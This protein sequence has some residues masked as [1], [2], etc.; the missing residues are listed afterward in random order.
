MKLST[1]RILT[2]HTGSLPRP[3]ELVRLTY[4]QEDGKPV[5]HDVMAAAQARAVEQVVR[6]QAEAGIDVISDGE[7]AKPGFINYLTSRLTGYEGRAG[8]WV[9]DDLK[10]FP[11]L[12]MEQYGGEAGA[13][14][15]MRTCT[16]DIRYVGQD[17]VAADIAM[18]SNTIADAGVVEG[19]LPAASPGSFAMAAPNQHY[20]S[21]E[22][23]LFA[24]ARA[25]REEYRAVVGSGLLLQLDCPDLPM[26]M[27]TTGWDDTAKRIGY[28]KYLELHVAAL[29]EAVADLP[30]DR[31]RMHICWGNYEGPHHLDVPLTE[32]LPAVFEARPAAIS[33]EAANPRHEHEWED[34]A[35]LK[36]PDDKIL[37]PG[38]IDVKTNVLEHPRLVAQRVVRFADI[39][40]RERVIAGT[41]CGFGTFV[42]FGAINDT[43]AWLKLGALAQGARLASES[44]WR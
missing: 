16:G 9:L 23:Y 12:L 1:D 13:H 17:A 8:A 10:E 20:D 22:D 44:L 27:H 21:Y 31:M 29:N 2:T 37:V 3:E 35:K 43:V 4:E 40:G 38:V 26:A 28:Q 30:P 25:L 36:I 33:F 18:L 34:L 7:M 14:I 19:F 41:D 24:I 42:G 15:V 6:S 32:V 39:V 11:S 5:D